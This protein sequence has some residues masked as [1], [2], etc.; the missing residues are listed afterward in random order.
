[1]SFALY[2]CLKIR[3]VRSPDV[4]YVVW[5]GCG[6]NRVARSREAV[7]GDRCGGRPG[8][9]GAPGHLPRPARPER[10]GQVDYDADAH[11]PGAPERG[12]DP[13]AGPRPA[14]AVQGS[15]GA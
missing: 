13:R 5:E 15:A 2:A 11:R 14:R 10:R 4:E 8:P 12:N 6:R 9:G 7:R 3:N 1:M